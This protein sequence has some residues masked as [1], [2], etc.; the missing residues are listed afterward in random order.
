MNKELEY[1][2]I[3]RNLFSYDYNKISNHGG[4]VNSISIES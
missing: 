4:D 3:W 1:C 2:Y